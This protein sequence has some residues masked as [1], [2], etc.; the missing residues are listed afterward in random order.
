L[1]TQGIVDPY[2]SRITSWVRI[3]TDP[4]TPSAMRTRLSVPSAA[5]RRWPD[6]TRCGCGRPSKC[7]AR[8]GP[9]SRASRYEGEWA[10][11]VLTSLRALKGLTYE[12]TGGIVAAP[13]AALPEALGGVR[14]WDYR[15]CWVRDAVLTL[16]AFL[17]CGYRDAAEAF[18][19]WMI[20]ATAGRPGDLQIM[21]GIAGERRLP[22]EE[23]LVARIR[24][25]RS[26]AHR[27]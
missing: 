25:L 5:C 10:E 12:P 22:E 27:Q 19:R 20:R 26:R 4:R 9:A 11:P 16:G 17:R 6:E 13:T 8:I 7:A 23:R 21:Y 15:F 2:S 18:R 24:G 14:N 3:C 1:V